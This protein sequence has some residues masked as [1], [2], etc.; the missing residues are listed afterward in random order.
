VSELYRKAKERVDSTP[1]LEPY[2]ADILYDWP[3]GEEHWQWV[4]NADV[5]EIVTWAEQ[6]NVSPPNHHDPH[7]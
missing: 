2:R 1:E 3:E 5:Q 6:F 7:S 4:V